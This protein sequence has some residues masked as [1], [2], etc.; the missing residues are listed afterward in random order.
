MP[1]K[2][3][4]AAA[5]DGGT[6]ASGAGSASSS[7]CDSPPFTLGEG[8]PPIPAKLV[9]KICK[10]EFVN[11]A[12]L[13]RDN[14]EAERRR[15]YSQCMETSRGGGSSARRE[16][17]DL[18]S[19]LQCFGMYAAVAASKSPDS[20]PQ[21]LVYQTM[22]VRELRRCWGKGW[23]NYDTMFWQQAAINPSCDWSKLNNTLYSCTFMAQQNGRGRT[24]TW[25]LETDH[26]YSV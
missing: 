17:P 2:N 10:G 6:T 22:I 19:W 13:L 14:M 5:V 20:I 25:C 23:L 9:G 12:E 24:C 21:L 15:T 11:I 16:I 3:S 18:L 7:K 1:P 8:L 26:N 4:G